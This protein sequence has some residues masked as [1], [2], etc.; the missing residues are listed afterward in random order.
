MVGYLSG[1]KAGASLYNLFHH[2]GIAILVILAGAYF[3]NDI[4]KLI[5][6]ILFSH[7]SMDRFFGYGLKTNEGFAFTH[8]G[9]IGKDKDR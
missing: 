7:S 8:L 2:K 9:K 4:V 1:N 3:N 5:G 6:I